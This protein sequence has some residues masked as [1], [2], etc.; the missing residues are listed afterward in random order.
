MEN[1]LDR[2]R[3]ARTHFRDPSDIQILRY[4][5]PQNFC[6][7]PTF[8]GSSTR[9]AYVYYLRHNVDSMPVSVRLA[10]NAGR[11]VTFSNRSLD[12]CVGEAR[13]VCTLALLCFV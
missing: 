5:R 13:E 11:I 6:R 12:L 1:Q 4:D 7:Y 9:V 8:R 2:E 10:P 3:Y